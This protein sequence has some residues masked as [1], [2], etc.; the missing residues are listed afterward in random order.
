MRRFGAIQRQ[1]LRQRMIGTGQGQQVSLHAQPRQIAAH[2]GHPLQGGGARVGRIARMARTG[3]IAEAE[4]RIIVRGAD[5]PVEIDFGEHF[6]H[7]ISSLRATVR[8]RGMAAS[9]AGAG[10]RLKV[11]TLNPPS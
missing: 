11:I 4:T 5:D 9:A 10:K 6:S 2:L 7:S 3:D 1:R 8:S